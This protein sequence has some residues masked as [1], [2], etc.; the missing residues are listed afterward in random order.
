MA[1]QRTLN[2]QPTSNS[3]N[4]TVA[5]TNAS[6][7]Q[8]VTQP[9][10]TGLAGIDLLISNGAATVAHLRWGT[11]AQTAV[12]TDFAVLPGETMVV[13]MGVAA[14]NIAVILESGSGNVYLSLGIG[15]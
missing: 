14:T 6:T 9:N 4:Y 13:N 2:F 11:V 3:S 12:T 1:V 15:S 5:A 10:N 7:N 8:V